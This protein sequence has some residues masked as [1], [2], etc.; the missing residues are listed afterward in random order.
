M[1][2]KWNRRSLTER[3]QCACRCKHKGEGSNLELRISCA[4]RNVELFNYE[5]QIIN[6][7]VQTSKFKEYSIA[8]NA[9]A[10]ASESTREVN[11]EIFKALRASLSFIIYPLAKR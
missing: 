5:V 6:F 8:C 7:K 3:L 2:K 4:K 11:N 9:F 10:G 1:I